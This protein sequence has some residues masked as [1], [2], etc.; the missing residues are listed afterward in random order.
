LKKIKKIKNHSVQIKSD[1][2][3]RNLYF[4]LGFLLLA[5]TFIV[6]SPVMSNMFLNYDDNKFITENS[7]ITHLNKESL[8][9]FFN[10]GIYTPFYKPLVYLSWALEYHFFQF[11]PFYFHLDNLILHMMNVLLIFFI[12]RFII[13]KQFAGQ[14]PLSKIWVAFFIALL[15][16]IHPLK[17]ESV[18]W[19]MERKDMLFGF[20]FFSSMYCY[21]NFV[22]SEKYIYLFFSSI[23]FLLGI[24]S[25]SMIITLPFSLLVIDYAIGRNFNKKLLI[26]KI[27]FFLIFIVGLYLYGIFHHFQNLTQGITGI[28]SKDASNEINATIVHSNPFLLRVVV[29]S[30]RIVLLLFKIIVPIHCS[31]IYKLPGFFVTQQLSLID[32]IYPFII[33]LIIGLCIYLHRISRIVPAGFL[34]F[35]VNII[36]ILGMVGSESSMVSDRYNYISSAGIIYILGFGLIKIFKKNK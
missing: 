1:H 21:L 30:Y 29:T 28:I 19:I 35:F 32:F 16:S 12:I 9:Y 20:F 5:I 3:E 6:F 13:K 25:K 31:P 2:K 23:L 14:N 36:P 4:I 17:V 22:K 24:F 15:Y 34:F 26:E 10:I 7:F 33:L 11:N 18:A 8:Y 27:P